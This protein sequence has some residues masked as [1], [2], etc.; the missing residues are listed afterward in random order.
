[1]I[2]LSVVCELNRSWYRI[3]L[4]VIILNDLFSI[5]PSP[6]GAIEYGI[7]A[8]MVSKKMLM[9]SGIVV[10]CCLALGTG[11]YT[12]W[13]MVQPHYDNVAAVNARSGLTLVLPQPL[14]T[15]STIIDQPTYNDTNHSITTR[16]KVN[17][18]AVTLSQ[19]AR[20]KADLKQIDAEDTFLVNAGSA[21]ILKGEQGR[22]Q[23]ILETSDSWL[24]VNANASIGTSAF[25]ALLESLR[26]I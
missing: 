13:R 21:Y 8:H 16:L 20:P 14:P 4:A 23:A 18:T 1:M 22:L 24:M 3:V 5:I 2:F 10:L 26:A 9:R 17:N 11:A 15:G 6:H 25:K 12:V 7:I 19:Q